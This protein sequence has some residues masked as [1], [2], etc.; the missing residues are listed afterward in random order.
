MKNISVLILLLTGLVWLPSR[1]AAAPSSTEIEIIFDASDS[2]NE[3]TKE[4]IMKID[5]AK[6]AL[7]TLAN[8]IPA[9]TQVGL[10]VFGSNPASNNIEKAC[11]DSVLSIPISPFQ[12]ETLENQTMGLAAQGRTPIGYSL[13]QAANDFS[14]GAEKKI[15]ILI[16]DGEESCGVDPIGV[17]RDLQARGINVIVH[18]LG[19]D[20]NEKAQA[21]LRQIATM[22]SGTYAN[23]QSAQE[24]KLELTKLAEK[25]VELQKP[26]KEIGEN[27][28]AAAN[29]AQIVSAS[30]LDF[31]KLIDGKEEPVDTFSLNQEAVFSFK[32]NKPVLLEKFAIPIFKEDSSNPG[33]LQLFGSIESPNS[34]F[35]HIRTVKVQNKVSFGNVYQEFPIQ[36]PAAIRYLKVVIGPDAVGYNGSTHAEWVAYGKFL[37]DEELAQYQKKRD[38]EDH[39]LLAASQGGK[40]IAASSQDYSKVIDGSE[41]Q[42][43]EYAA[44]SKNDEAIFGFKEGKTALVKKV[45]LPIFKAKDGNV[46]TIE[47]WVSEESPTSGYKKAGTFETTDLVFADNPYQEYNFEK[48]V[49]AKYLK[50]KIVDFHNDS[51]SGYLYEFRAIGTLES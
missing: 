34:G 40:I 32:E 9:G 30:S 44:I 1:A 20:A 41:D 19:F 5:A 45:S 47:I 4:G 27:I 21:Q 31:A 39:N 15:I 12:K 48:P 18:T 23:A 37:S 8:Q 22:T 50:I 6:D 14:A 46:K 24:L 33:T 35:F 36:P 43:G 38:Q 49:R 10:R 7:K 13:Q 11:K 26:K 17:I 29:G 51:P 2:M 16:S 25:A 28:L 42:P 3:A